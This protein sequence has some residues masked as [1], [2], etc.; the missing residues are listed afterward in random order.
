MVL[1]PPASCDS[2]VLPC[3]CGCPIQALIGLPC[4]RSF[5]VILHGHIEGPPRMGS[6]SVDQCIRHLKG[7]LSGVLLC[8]SVHQAFDGPASLLFS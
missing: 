6:Y 1:A 8:S 3:F 2:A 7:H 5:S 4:L